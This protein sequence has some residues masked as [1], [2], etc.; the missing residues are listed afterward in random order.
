MSNSCP[1]NFEKIDANRARLGSLLVFLS[2]LVYLYNG[3][4][5]I[6]F[7]LA[8]DFAIRLFYKSS[9]APSV[10]I[11]TAVGAL[12]KIKPRYTDGGAKRLA[13]YFGFL[14][15]LLLLFCHYF[16]ND[17]VTLAV[18]SLFL[19]CSF[20]DIFF[21]FCIGCKIYYIIKKVYPDF[22]H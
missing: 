19:S 3:F 17:T 9:L 18:A 6:L 2:V 22:M 16:A 10:L 5:A 8:F 12:F 4:V 14:F 7:F 15:V 20:L 13:A 11:A 21:N 1:L